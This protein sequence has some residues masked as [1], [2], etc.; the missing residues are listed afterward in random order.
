MKINFKRISAIA[1]SILL[2]GM[3]LG[4]AAAASYPAP[5][6]SGGSANVAVVYGT[7]AGVSA[8]DTIQAGNI[9]SNLQ[10][11][12]SGSTGSSSVVGG[13]SFK[14]EKTST[15]FQLGKGIRDMTG[16]SITLDD[17]PSLLADGKYIDE[18]NDEF[19]YTQKIEVSNITLGLFDDDDYK[20]DSPTVG[21]TIPDGRNVLNYTLD[22]TD[23][24][25]MDNLVTTDIPIMGR[26]YYV[27]SVGAGSDT[28][29]KLTLLDSAVDTVLAE[30]ESKTLDVDGTSYVVS[31]DFISATEV[32]LSVNGESTN[33]IMEAQTYKLSDGSY[34]GIKD[35]MHD[36]KDGSV[37]KV[38]F[39]IGKGKLVLNSGSTVE[40]NEKN[41]EGLTATVTNTTV[42][43]SIQLNWDAEDDLFITEDS[44]ILMPGFNAVKLSFGGVVFPTKESIKVENSGEN[45]IALKSFP[46]KDSKE[47]I[48]LLYYNGTNYTVIGKESPN[49]LLVTV[50]SGNLT[51]DSDTDDYF[52]ASWDDGNDAESYLMQAT[53]FKTETVDK[54][55]F[56]YRKDNA[57]VD[58]KTDA[59]EGDTVKMGNIELLVG[60]VNNTNNNVIVSPGTN[61]NFHT[62]YSKEGMK[63]YLPFNSSTSTDAGAINL[64]STHYPATF[65]L[66]FS[67]EDKDGN[68]GK[69]ANITVTLG[70][71]ASH[72]ADVDSYA[73]SGNAYSM[74]GSGAEIESTD[75]FQNYAY[76]ALATEVLFD[77]SSDQ[78]TLELVYHGDESYGEL[79]IM[80]PEA[81]V[82]TGVT[83]GAQIGEILVKDSEVS[84]VSSKNLILVGG[85]CINSAAANVLGGAYCGAAF[86]EATGVGSGQFLIKGVASAYT[87][88]KIALVVAGYDAA[89]TVNAAKFLT[90]QT[91]DTSKAYVGTSSTSAT[92]VVQ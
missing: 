17:M 84:S 77:K 66:I 69:G 49:N 39:S 40:L 1:T 63:V 64:N 67:E 50:A 18:N 4:V 60:P 76:S 32:K 24:P 61:V 52:I 85:S 26:K 62:L 8:L 73:I 20:Q 16:T 57:W 55:T 71:D 38:E 54:V 7:G 34:L 45:N 79:Y 22:F 42:L 9:Q 75:V 88:G 43:Q 28:G 89:D 27:L 59:K 72:E 25:E 21:Y 19:D 33:S 41:V 46:L 78:E 5:F 10:S 23:E 36:T 44:S 82:T 35:I 91:V 90:T 92:L 48:T 74:T 70:E 37:S 80:S 83:D 58:A 68:P 86:T 31:I 65:N 13:D 2:T 3:T 12:M 30:G 6:V 14:F 29:A 56:Q 81:S 47:D 53:N 15:K 87:E 51:F 11:Y